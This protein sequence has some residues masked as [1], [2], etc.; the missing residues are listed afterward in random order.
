MF[1]VGGYSITRVHRSCSSLHSLFKVQKHLKKKANL[2]TI[3]FCP[4]IRNL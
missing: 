1:I 2:Q 4:Q 3:S